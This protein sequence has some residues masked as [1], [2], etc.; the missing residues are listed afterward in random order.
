MKYLALTLK[1]TLWISALAK[2]VLVRVLQYLR[3]HRIAI[4]AILFALIGAFNTVVDIGVFSFVYFYIGTQIFVANVAAW[5]VAVSSS[6][7][8]NSSITFAVESRGRLSVLTYFAFAMT[9]LAGFAVN[10]AGVIVAAYFIP[11]LYAKIIATVGSLIVN[12][13]LSNSFV[14]GRN[15]TWNDG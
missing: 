11:V 10:T 3:L 15:S 2:G 6:Y 8:L 1:S 9:Q 7:V 4:K 14:F 13:W 12:F 5:V